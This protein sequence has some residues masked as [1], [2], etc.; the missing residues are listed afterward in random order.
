M[1]RMFV[2]FQCDEVERQ[3]KAS[4]KL[5]QCCIRWKRPCKWAYVA[6]LHELLK[7]QLKEWSKRLRLSLLVAECGLYN[8]SVNQTLSPSSHHRKLPKVLPNFSPPST[9]GIPH[10]ALLVSSAAAARLSTLLPVLPA[11]LKLLHICVWFTSLGAL[12]HLH[13]FTLRPAVDLHN[14]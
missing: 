1:S 2:S 14:G 11:L 12:I 10:P 9:C 3:K 5:L 13:L 4:I 6:L 7:R 8:A